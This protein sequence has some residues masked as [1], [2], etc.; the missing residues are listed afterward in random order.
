MAGVFVLSPYKSQSQN[1]N[2]YHDKFLGFLS[3]L[4]WRRLNEL[5]PVARRNL[6]CML[7]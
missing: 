5:A 3:D 4:N 1:L 7:H 2:L 6:R